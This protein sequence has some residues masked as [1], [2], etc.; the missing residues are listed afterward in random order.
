M[1]FGIFVIVGFWSHL[2]IVV[3]FACLIAKNHLLVLV[4][5]VGVS[6]RVRWQDVG[7]DTI[8]WVSR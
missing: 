1:C 5:R 4:V 6:V 2:K 7:V 3:R 8:M